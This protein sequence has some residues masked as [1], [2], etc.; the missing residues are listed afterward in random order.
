MSVNIKSK[1]EEEKRTIE[2]MIS[3]YCKKK[4]KS[5]TL[6]EDCLSLKKYANDRIDHCPFME[7]KTFCSNCKVHCYKADMRIKVKEVMRY[8]GPRMLFHKPIMVIRHMYYG[9]K[10][11]S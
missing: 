5:K 11:N 7:S 4:H 3:Y 2:Y 8:S 1:R 10:E 9:R 6:C